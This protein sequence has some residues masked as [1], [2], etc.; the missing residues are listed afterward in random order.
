MIAALL[1]IVPVDHVEHYRCDVQ[2]WNVVADLSNPEPCVH[3]RHVIMRDL[4]GIRDWRANHRPTRDWTTGDY[5]TRWVEGGKVIEVRSPV[6]IESVTD[7]DRELIERSWLPEC[8][9]RRVNK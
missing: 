3:L 4:D 7:Y 8:Q 2:E 5:V 9:R 6:L 1:L